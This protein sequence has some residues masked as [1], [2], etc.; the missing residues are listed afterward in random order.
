MQTAN[1]LGY[2]HGPGRD[3]N[4][5]MGWSTKPRYQSALVGNWFENV[6]AKTPDFKPKV[7]PDIHCS[8]I[9]DILVQVKS[10]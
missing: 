4:F 8:V 6:V 7:R 10:A 1:S 9:F 3:I 5:E 2:S